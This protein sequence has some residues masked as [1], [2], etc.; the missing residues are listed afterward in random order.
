MGYIVGISVHCGHAL[1]WQILSSD[2]NRHIN[3]SLVRPFDP[4][5]P[6]LRTDL[7]CGG[8]NK[9]SVIKS[10]YDHAKTSDVSNTTSTHELDDSVNPIP[11]AD[12]EDLVGRTFLLDKQEDS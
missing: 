5:H 9:D 12:V 2:N 6:N 7:L 1:T 4:S 8:L 11:L 3:R 10:R